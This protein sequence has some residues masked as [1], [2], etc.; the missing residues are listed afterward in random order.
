MKK[1]IA[2]LAIALFLGSISAPT[3]ASL[4]NQNTIVTFADGKPKKADDSK[5]K[6]SSDCNTEAKTEKNCKSACSSAE[7]KACDKDKK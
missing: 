1:L 5:T 2:G 6:K 4:S 7:K 3:F